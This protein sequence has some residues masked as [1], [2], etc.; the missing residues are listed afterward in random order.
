MAVDSKSNE[1]PAVRDLLKRMGTK[2]KGKTVTMDA[3]HAQ[4]QTLEYIVE[5]NQA[6]YVVAIKGNQPTIFNLVKNELEQV[7]LPENDE[8]RPRAAKTQE[9]S[10]SR[11]G[12]RT[13]QVSHNVAQINAHEGWGHVKAVA[14]TTSENHNGGIETRYFISGERLDSEAM[15]RIIREHWQI[16]N[17]QHYVLDVALSEDG[18]R[19][20][21]KNGAENLSLLRKIALNTFRQIK[22]VNHL[23]KPL[24]VVQTVKN[25]RDCHNFRNKFVQHIANAA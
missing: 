25:L 17:C 5:N 2:I 20:N 23:G 12:R 16:E 1:I 22:P 11:P 14:I 18:N 10:K 4:I 8:S 7:M 13:C 6:N 9:K 21:I 19:I 15:L 24:S 3:M